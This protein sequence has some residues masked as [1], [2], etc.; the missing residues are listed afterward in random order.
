MRAVQA[1]LPDLLLQLVLPDRGAGEDT[2]APDP[3]VEKGES[4]LN[5]AGEPLA[6]GGMKAGEN[7]D[8]TEKFRQKVCEYETVDEEPV[9][10]PIAEEP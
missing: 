3:P 1:A 10:G 7:P 2:C 6:T 8:F 4:A 5:G 9:L